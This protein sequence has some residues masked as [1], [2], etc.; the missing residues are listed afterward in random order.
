MPAP[1]GDG[2]RWRA[3]LSRDERYDGMFVTAVKT[4]G[5]Y[6]RP[7]CPARHP[8]RANVSFF[9]DADAAERDGYRACRRCKPRDAAPWRERLARIERV[10]RHIERSLDE[11]ITL[12][13]LAAVAGLS[14]YHLQRAFLRAT[15]V[16]PA[17]YA[18]A[19]RMERLKGHLRTPGRKDGVTMAVYEAGYGSSSRLYERAP[20][21]L[22]MTPS[23]YRA[24][25][26]GASIA[27]ATASTPVGR[28]LVGATE[29]GVCSVKVGATEAELARALRDEFPAA[30]IRRDREGVGRRL[31]AVLGAIEGREPK[32]ALPLDIRATAFQRRVWEALCRIPRGET[33]TYAEI[34]REVGRPRAA[35]AVGRACATNPVAIVVPCHRVVGTSGE[36]TGYAYGVSVK[37]ALLRREGAAAALSAASGEGPTKSS[38]RRRRPSR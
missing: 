35:R 36:L 24:G 15:G 19:R 21:A 4:T 3:V 13:D 33:R 2:Q 23:A 29:R 18:D 9:A 1:R 14:P 20:K 31:E 11:R 16:S 38:R 26:A 7:S 27:Y 8:A 6:C 32:E 12:R 34:A 28:V 30:A 17:A 25:G 10:C 37:R 22:G 5:I